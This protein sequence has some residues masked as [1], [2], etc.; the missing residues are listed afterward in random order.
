MIT[1]DKI[2]HARE[3]QMARCCVANL[4][5]AVSFHHILARRAYCHAGSDEVLLLG[6]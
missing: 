5:S 4:G 3:R 6:H 2:G 1:A